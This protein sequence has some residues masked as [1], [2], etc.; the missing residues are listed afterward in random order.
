MKHNPPSVERRP[1][2]FSDAAGGAGFIH[3]YPVNAQILNKNRNNL[4]KI[5][6]FRNRKPKINIYD[7]ISTLTMT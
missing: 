7:K 3:A 1:S 6:N 2:G 5:K 4:L